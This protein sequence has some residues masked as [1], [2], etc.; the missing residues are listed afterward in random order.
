MQNNRLG[1]NINAKILVLLFTMTFVVSC[2]HST[3]E[4]Y[5][6]E[7][8][9]DYL[10]LDFRSLDESINA[11][12]D[13]IFVSEQ[14]KY[15]ELLK[16]KEGRCLRINV[17]ARFLY[18]LYKFSGRIEEAE[19]LAENFGSDLI[20]PS[21]SNLTAVEY[22]NKVLDPVSY[23]MTKRW[24]RI[25]RLKQIHPFII[26]RTASDRDPG[27]TLEC[28]KEFLNDSSFNYYK[29]VFPLI[30]NYEQNDDLNESISICKKIVFFSEKEE[31][32]KNEETRKF[33]SKIAGIYLIRLYVLCRKLDRLGEVN[34]YTVR[35]A[36][37]LRK[38]ALDK[39]DIAL[40]KKSNNMLLNHLFDKVIKSYNEDSLKLPKN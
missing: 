11:Y 37:I 14:G 36:H 22:N 3:L 27:F 28:T 9:M 34:Q 38:Q 40:S 31:F 6:N 5:Y 19:E 16:S 17:T 20:V 32:Q 39:N 7:T 30:I 15:N 29:E 4:D 33:S 13:I 8:N 12:K 1:M 23:G 24:R 10:Y 18:V 21:M 25:E 35:I 2:N 26:P